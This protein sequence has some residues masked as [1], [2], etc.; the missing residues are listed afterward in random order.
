MTLLL[1]SSWLLV[2]LAGYG[3]RFLNLRHLKAVGRVVPPVF[4]GK[5]DPEA[6]AKTAAYTLH[7]SRAGLVQSIF[8]NVLF[9]AFVFGGG[10]GIYDRWIA[11]VVGTGPGAGAV[12]FLGLLW[13]TTLLGIPFDLYDTFRIEGRY[14]FNTTTGRLWAADFLK[15]L[16]ISGVL[17]GLL[18]WGGLAFVRWAPQTWWL[19]VWA[20]FVA[21]SVFLLFL[22]PYVIEPLFFKFGPVEK[23]GLEEKIRGLMESSGLA[24]GR[25]FQVDASRRS[26]HSNAY[27]TGIGKVKRVVLF[28]TLL[29]QMEAS[30]ILAVLAHEI[31]HWKGRHVLKRLCLTGLLALGALYLAFRL[32]QWGGLPGL[33]GLTTA[34]LPAQTL[35]LWFMAT[36]VGFF[37]TPL[38][39]FLARRD[40]GE[41]D[42]F[43]CRATGD[44]AALASALVKLSLENLANL[45]PHPLY[46]RFYYSHPPIVERVG[47]LSP[48][49]S[50]P[51]GLQ[52]S[53]ES[54]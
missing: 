2:V 16:A 37:L 38:F 30:E 54:R 48:P 49:V 23:E 4:R 14:G 10:L 43:A 19:W 25:V 17:L 11:S 12:F 36:V 40:E 28:D 53:Q 52:E 1:V 27:F 21:A 35:V 33:A 3:L 31:G 22:S 26:R 13:A 29:E 42:G 32:V 34:S 41:A 8:D 20:L 51:G 39:S 9:L 5:V 6:L 46:A 15:S 7:K 18:A 50:S 24:V 47:S 44:A 45:H